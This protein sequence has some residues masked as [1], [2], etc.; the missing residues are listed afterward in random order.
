MKRTKRFA[1][2][3]LVAMFIVCGAVLAGCN[4]QHTHTYSDAWEKDPNGH[5]HVA[6]C[7]DL[8]E[9]DKDYKKDYAAHVWGGDDECD[10]C[11]YIKTSTVTEYKVTLDANGG[12][13]DGDKETAEVTTKSGK[14]ETLPVPAAPEGMEFVGWFTEDNGGEKVT[15][16]TAF[17]SNSTIYA[18]YVMVYTITLNAGDGTLAT[19]T[20]K[21]KD[22]KITEL[23]TPTAPAG[24][25]FV[26]WYT[27]AVD[28]EQVTGVQVTVETDFDEDTTIYAR[29][30]FVYT[31]KLNVGEGGTLPA[32]TATTLTT[33][34]GKI[35]SLPVPVTQNALVFLGWF[36]AADG[37]NKVTEDTVFTGD[38]LEITIYAR[39]AQEITVTLTVG[40]GTLPAGASS[41]MI[42]TGNKLPEL[43][44]PVAPENKWFKGWFTA[45]TGG[46]LVTATTD[47]SAY[48][49]NANAVTLFA[50]Y[51]AEVTVTLNAGSEG[52]LPEGAI[53]TYKTVNGKIELPEGQRGLPAVTTSKE[54]WVF[55]GWYNGSSAVNVETTIFE[56]DAE[57][58]AKVGREDGVWMGEKFV[59]SLTRN[60]GSS[61]T[62][63]W[64]GGGKITL[65]KGDVITLYMNGIVVNHFVEPSSAGIVKPGASAIVG[66]VTVDVTGEFEI[67][68]H[69]NASDW[70]CQYSGPTEVIVGS[71]IPAGCDTVTVKIGTNEPIMFFIKDGSGNGVKKDDF[72]K[73]CI[74]TYQDELF[75]NW[76]GSTTNGKL[77]EEM[78][79][80]KTAVPAGWI[81]R[82]GSGFGNQTADIKG[83]FKA[84]KTYLVELPKANKGSP[85]ITELSITSVYTITLDQ[86]YEGQPDTKLTAKAY[87]G[88]LSYI[89]A[90]TP[91][92][93]EDK[94]LFWYTAAEG[95]EKVTT[96]TEFTANTT[97]YARWSEK[98]VM[99]VDQN[100]EGK[101]ENKTQKIDYGK[102]NALPVADTRADYDFVG[103]FTAAEGGE[104]VTTST[105][106]A[107]NATIYA[108]W[109][110]KV[111]IT[112]DQNYEGK[113]ENAI[114]KLNNGKFKTL[115]AQDAREDYDFLG[116]YTAAEG[117]E[118]VTLATVFEENITIY[119]QWKLKIVITVDQNYEG[120]TENT[121]VKANNGKISPLPAN[122]VRE[123]YDFVGWF[124]EAEGGTRVT[125][126]TVFTE[127]TT[128]YA[129]W[130]LKFVIT[131]DQNYEGKP[132]NTTV[133]TTNDYLSEIPAVESREG[134]EFV[135]WFTEPEGG[136]LI[137]TTTRFTQD[138]TIYGQWRVPFK[139]TFNYNYEGCADPTVVTANVVSGQTY[140]RVPAANFPADPEREGYN[141][142]GWY[143]V[144]AA[145]GGTRVRTSTNITVDTAVY[146]RWQVIPQVTFNYNY[147][148][149]PAS[150]TVTTV[151]N[152]VPVAGFPADPARE[153]LEFVG[154]FTAEEGGDEVDK[155]YIFSASATVYA[156]WRTPLVITFELNYKGQPDTKIILNTVARGKIAALPETPVREG[157]VFYYWSTTAANGGYIVSNANYV[158]TKDTVLYA[159]WREPA[160]VTFDLNYEGQ[161]ETKETAKT[162]NGYVITALPETPV[163]EGF[164]FVGWFTAAEGG[165]EITIEKKYT[166]DTTV[167][168]HWAP[169]EQE[170]QEEEA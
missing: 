91:E 64:L 59:H 4:N 72:G 110:L 67:Y 114:V 14:I 136:T 120:K 151:S 76:N 38:E 32:G 51:V 145:T 62:E 48:I 109:K 13:L 60:D 16:A 150:V 102:F 27:T 159:H 99:T 168:A 89:P 36:T 153:G 10:V 129:Q 39:Y 117:G 54:H 163:R 22:G 107:E 34:G 123:D 130:K 74:Y 94:D 167:Y 134:L 165:T 148:G 112:V 58:T 19:T 23:P 124:T 121:M 79:V 24:K 122:D 84:G 50:R 86:N 141:F 11:H 7:D 41:T 101:P 126:T 133:K 33:K 104:Q 37:G 97:I 162:V 78:V 88:K 42:T 3:V 20:L 6:T 140:S 115:P 5:W 31:I 105:V 35:E 149:A 160:T 66:T 169:V 108:Q 63:Y 154:W 111:V 46:T 147:E 96:D 75:G 57:L 25:Q 157:Y 70:S 98:I 132:E 55:F 15:T 156:R 144:A 26:G 87:N 80:N 85:K 131:L 53:T 43:P 40:E 18:H 81:F 106:F 29:Y 49:N 83:V 9:G 30:A 135:G 143:T 139:V 118:Q 17:T 138:T 1:T 127:N 103:W 125:A 100:Y 137:K 92:G 170:T 152:K 71:E 95:G 68:L 69:R 56:S 82:W 77:K 166:K 142:V 164:T 128:V 90:F 44:T 47:L 65:K 146:A 52:T 73:F 119:A 8:K 161:P 28:T 116:W 12:K 93:Y 158:Y 61:R 155:D 21:A 2:F 113:P 45:E